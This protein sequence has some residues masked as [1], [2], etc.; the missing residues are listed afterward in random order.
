MPATL[1]VTGLDV[2]FGARILVSGLDLTLADGD[3]TALVGPNGSGKSTLMRML[4]G[5]LPVG[6]GS[7]RLAP[8]DATIAWLPQ[9]LPAHDESL[10]DY[11]R[12]RTGVA[13]ADRALERGA[14]ALAAGRPGGEEDYARALERWLGP[15]CRRPRPI[16]CPRS[17]RGWVCASTRAGR[18]ARCR[19]ARRR[20]PRWWRCSS[21]STTCCSSTSPPTTSTSAV[22][23]SWSSSCGRTR[24][25]CSW[26]AT[27]AAS[28][29]RSPPAW[30]SST[31][32]QAR[33]GHYTGGWSDYVAARELARGQAR[34]AYAAYAAARD[35]LVGQARQR[36]E[37]AAKGHR[38][39]RRGPGGR[40]APA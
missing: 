37:W 14:E 5:D 9:V 8:P 25:R 33:V 15:R 21:A 12:R 29:T 34:E 38:A 27:T 31:S 1:T 2:S 26:P 39:V 10:L 4:V 16:G 32:H 28:S 30:S 40:Q 35:T 23:S 20:G 17:P 24:G 36:Q 11:A 19:A 3:V 6:T 13:A 22:G 7:V 18:S